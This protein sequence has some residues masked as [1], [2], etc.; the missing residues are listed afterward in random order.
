METSSILSFEEE[1][2]YRYISRRI[3][4]L[5]SENVAMTSGLS[6]LTPVNKKNNFGAKAYS[7][8]CMQIGCNLFKR[9]LL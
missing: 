3:V 9:I 1:Y 2:E 5:A 8:H 4:S 6:Y 7:L